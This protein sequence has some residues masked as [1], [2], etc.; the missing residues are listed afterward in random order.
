LNIGY[1]TS[2][3]PVAVREEDMP[4]GSKMYAYSHFDADKGDV[5]F[6]PQTSVEAGC[7]FFV[8][9][10]VIA[11][12]QADLSGQTIVTQPTLNANGNVGGTFVTTVEYKDVGYSPRLKDNIF[13]PLAQNLHPFRACILLGNSGAPAEVCVRLM[14][15]DEA[16]QLKGILSKPDANLRGIYSLDGK[17]L[18]TPIKGQPYIENGKIMIR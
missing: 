8:Y 12:W 17:R 15:A 7:P 16:D 5:I 10:E 2:C 3:L 4:T 18:F 13:A 9:S 11:N 1:N 6:V 14:D